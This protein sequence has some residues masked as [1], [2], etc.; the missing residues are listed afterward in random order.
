MKKDLI[1]FLKKFDEFKDIDLKK[2]LEKPKLEKQGDVAFP[3]FILS[4][5]LKKNPVEIS[6]ELKDKLEKDKPKFIKNIVSEGPYL[7]FFYDDS[8]ICKKIVNSIKNKDYKNSFI[9][10]KKVVVEY[11]SPN[12]NKSLH[13]GHARNILLGNSLCNILKRG[14][15]EVIKVNLNN[16]RG[17]AICKVMLS[18]QLFGENK[19]PH[20]LGIKPDKF[21][22]DLYVLFEKKNKEYPDL[23]LDK[24]AQEMLVKWEQGDKEIREL[25][26]KILNWVFEGYKETYK[27]YKYKPD[28]EFFESDFYDKGKDIVLNALK[29][30]VEGFKKDEETGA[31]YV[32]LEKEGLGKKYLLRGDGTTVYMTQDIYLAKLKE[33]KFKPDKS[34]FIV[35][36][37]QKYHFH[38]LFTILE[39]LG[40]DKEKKN[41]HLSYGFVFNKDGK[42][43]S[44][45]KGEV[46]NADY[47]F[48]L[49]FEKSKKILEEKG[50]NVKDLENKCKIIAYSSLAFNMLKVN[51]LNDINFDIDKAVSFEGETGPYIQY[52]YARII[53]L[54]KKY[55]ESVNFEEFFNNFTNINYSIYNEKEINLIKLLGEYKSVLKESFEK[56]KPSAIANYILKLSQTFNEYYANNIILKGKKEEIEKKLYLCYLISQVIKD[57]LYLLNI[58]I[59]DEM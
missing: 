18:Y 44:S 32:D 54:F 56:Y 10:K 57:G 11:P 52:T 26:K 35:S 43:F 1:Q 6:K 47:L 58:N 59:L 41:Y 55:F 8:F 50:R 29:S 51:P 46:I 53:S 49:A 40:L 28:F 15:Y 21:V 37:E 39:R 25:W 14:G 4:K 38:V 22:S 48:N 36:N 20:V 16:D 42:K 12:T 33:E 24:K 19:D 2:I 23:E 9:E 17:I 34:I 13:V 30:N 7:N 5:K 45:R 27:L 3:C 31:V